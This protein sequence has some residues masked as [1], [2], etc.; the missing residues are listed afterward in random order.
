MN[1]QVSLT[2]DIVLILTVYVPLS[3]LAPASL[4]ELCALLCGHSETD[5]L[6]IIDRLRKCHHPSLAEGNKQKM[7]VG[8]VFLRVSAQAI[9]LLSSW[10]SCE[11]ESSL[12]TTK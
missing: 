11:S 4:G 6:T 2:D 7:E 3:T 5:Q 9:L 8:R 1:K 12:I 10:L